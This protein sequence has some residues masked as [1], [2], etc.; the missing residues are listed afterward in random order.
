MSNFN[1]T[2]KEENLKANNL[3]VTEAALMSEAKSLFPE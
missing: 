1:G 3:S 2:L